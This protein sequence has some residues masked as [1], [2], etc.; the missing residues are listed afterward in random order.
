MNIL[1]IA[2]L[3][4]MIIM[5]LYSG[6]NM[7]NIITKLTRQS[8][9]WAVAAQQD[10]SPLISILHANY[11]A[12]YLWALK[13]IATDSEIQK[14]TG[15]DLRDFENEIVKTQENA[16]KKVIKACPNFAPPSNSLTKIAGE[17]I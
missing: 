14:A 6:N 7:N 2:L 16:T 17:G 12:G 13:D 8:A 10:A 15:I 1:L 4:L 11:G 5:S 9:R 3:M